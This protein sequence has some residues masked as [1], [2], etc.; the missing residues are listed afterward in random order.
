LTGD[1]VRDDGAAF[2]LVDLEHLPGNRR[3]LRPDLAVDDLQR[4]ER[5]GRGADAPRDDVARLAARRLRRRVIRAGAAGVRGTDLV[6]RRRP[7]IVDRVERVKLVALER[8]AEENLLAPAARVL[9]D[10]PGLDDQAE[11][12]VAHD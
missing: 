8:R 5:T 10:V 11:P 4:P 6:R 1:H 12:D 2:E 7:V 3:D 9:L